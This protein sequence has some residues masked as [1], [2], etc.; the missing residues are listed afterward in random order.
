MAMNGQAKRLPRLEDANPAVY[1]D[2]RSSVHHR[3]LG[4]GEPVLL[5]HGLG[6]RGAD[7]ALQIPVLEKRFRLIVPDLPGCGLSRPPRSGYS[8]SGLAATLWSLLDELQLGCVNVV[9]FSMG[10]AIGLE[11]ALQRP[12]GVPRLALINS[13]ATYGNQW[14]KWVYARSCSALIRLVGMHRAAEIFAAGLF[15]EPWQYRLRERATAV[16]AAMPAGRYLS[17]AHALEHWDATGRLGRLR[18]RTLIVAA[19]HDHT[20][21]AEKR[22]LALRLGAS[23]VV[24]NGSRHGTPF[25]SSE[26]TNRSLLALLTDQALEA[27]GHLNCDTPSRAQSEFLGISSRILELLDD[28]TEGCGR[29]SCQVAPVRCQPGPSGWSLQ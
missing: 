10:G 1:K 14:R 28:A 13:L 29:D 26:A 15:P 25:D 2:V 7:W 17:M 4:R 23:M 24:V 6:G 11:M 22:A 9:G 21:L 27:F 19:E 12:H 3:I 18:S 20:P 5:I 16:V 8:I